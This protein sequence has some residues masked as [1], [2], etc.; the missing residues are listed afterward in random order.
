MG[1]PRKVLK[2]IDDLMSRGYGIHPDLYYK[3]KAEARDRDYF[4]L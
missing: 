2:F 4:G 3:I 1:D